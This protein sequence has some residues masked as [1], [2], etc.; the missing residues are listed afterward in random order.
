ML[1]IIQS[2]DSNRR[3]VSL[4]VGKY[5]DLGTKI[6]RFYSN[7]DPDDPLQ[8]VLAGDIILNSDEL[9]ELREIL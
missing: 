8:G 1:V 4:T 6:L 9:K 3:E 2:I 7:T 5:N